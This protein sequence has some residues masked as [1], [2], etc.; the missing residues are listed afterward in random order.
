MKGWRAEKNGKSD[1]RLRYLCKKWQ[2]VR[3]CKGTDINIL[4]VSVIGT[5]FC[6]VATSVLQRYKSSP[7]AEPLL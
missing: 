7:W 3:V 4:G 1:C 5:Q 2:E 6:L